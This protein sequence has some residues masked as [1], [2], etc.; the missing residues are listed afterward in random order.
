MYGYLDALSDVIGLD[1]ALRPHMMRATFVTLSLDARVPARDI[2]AS[3]G[4]VSAQMLHYYDRAHA[5]IRRNASHQLADY[6]RSEQP[7]A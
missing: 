3:A 7:R 6:L 4:W 1:F 5:S 2:I